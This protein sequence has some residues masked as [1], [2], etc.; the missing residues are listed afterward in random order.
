MLPWLRSHG[1]KNKARDFQ[2]AKLALSNPNKLHMQKMLAEPPKS[3]TEWRYMLLYNVKEGVLVYLGH[4]RESCEQIVR[5]IAVMYGITTHPPGRTSLVTG[6]SIV[7]E[8]SRDRHSCTAREGFDDGS[9]SSA[10]IRQ[11]AEDRVKSVEMQVGK[12]NRGTACIK[13]SNVVVAELGRRFAI[14]CDPDDQGECTNCVMFCMR[15]ILELK[16]TMRGYHI[17]RIC[18]E[19]A[20]LGKKTGDAVSVAWEELWGRTGANMSAGLD[21]QEAKLTNNRWREALNTTRT[22]ED[23]QRMLHAWRGLPR[24]STAVGFVAA[25]T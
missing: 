8:R 3:H 15:M 11:N 14:H 22:H 10:Q 1:L 7:P 6:T 4:D 23:P 18:E 9:T 13:V 19:R 17:S 2:K 12:V 16:L 25:A 24:K 21:S 20:D 5:E